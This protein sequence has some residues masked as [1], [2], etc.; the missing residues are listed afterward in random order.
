MDRFVLF[1]FHDMEVGGASTADLL[2]EI[3]GY[4]R[5]VKIVHSTD[6]RSHFLCS[7]CDNRYITLSCG[8]LSFVSS[9]VTLV[10]I[11]PFIERC[12]GS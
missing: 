12:P 4:R 10:S 6:T 9:P 8:Y 11:Q 7:L 3:V 2:M 5:V 1:H